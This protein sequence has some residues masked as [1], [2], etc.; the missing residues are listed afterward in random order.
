MTTLYFVCV[1]VCVKMRSNAQKAHVYV[2]A[3]ESRRKRCYTIG[4]C[5]LRS[6][7]IGTAD[8]AACYS[9]FIKWQ[10]I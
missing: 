1:C 3:A 10:L 5:L 2:Q 4:C 9:R 8:I 6:A 7:V